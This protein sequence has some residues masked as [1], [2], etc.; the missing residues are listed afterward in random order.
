MPV[1]DEAI[2]NGDKEDNDATERDPGWLPRCRGFGFR[3]QIGALRF[4]G[5]L[6][7]SLPAR[8]K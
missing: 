8:G 4:Y 6:F 2:R 5:R 1:V 7:C 3:S